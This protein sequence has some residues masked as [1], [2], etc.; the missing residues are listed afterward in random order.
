MRKR[1]ST[2][3]V[4]DCSEQMYPLDGES[5]D[6]FMN[7]TARLSAKRKA[8]FLTSQKSKRTLKGVGILSKRQVKK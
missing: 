2:I 3:A 7:R 5:K 8:E 4:L 6:D 1:V